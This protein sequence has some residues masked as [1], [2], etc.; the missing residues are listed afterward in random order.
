MSHP[1]RVFRST[2][3][4]L[5]ILY[6]MLADVWS[7][8]I[9][10]S[11][12]FS[13]SISLVFPSAGLILFY[14]SLSLSGRIILISYGTSRMLLLQGLQ[15]EAYG[16]DRGTA[17]QPH[18]FRVHEPVLRTLLQIVEDDA[19]QPAEIGQ[20]LLPLRIVIRNSQP[21]STP[22]RPFPS[23]GV[24]SRSPRIIIRTSADSASLDY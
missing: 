7:C 16:S 19:G 9:V 24:T 5:I 22:S 21:I 23:M 12:S 20:R 2:L 11:R 18:L 3:S 10:L 8:R 17:K 6:A 15:V 14:G 13:S 4:S 1:W